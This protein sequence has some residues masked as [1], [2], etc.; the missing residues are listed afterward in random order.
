MAPGTGWQFTH[1]ILSMEVVAHCPC[2]GV[3]PCSQ[4]LS[5]ALP[6]WDAQEHT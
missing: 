3:L 1:T 2:L 4:H 5:K 6:P